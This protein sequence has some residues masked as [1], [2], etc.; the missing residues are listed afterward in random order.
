MTEKFNILWRR[1]LDIAWVVLLVLMPITSFPILSRLA[2]NTSVAPASFIPLVWLILFWFTYYLVKR[3]KVPRESIPFLFFIFVALVSCALG[4]FLDIPPFKGGNVINAEIR[5]LATLAVGAAFYFVTSSW[6]SQSCSRLEA[7]FKW[8]NFSGLLVFI[9]ATIQCVFIYLNHG[10]YPQYALNFQSLISSGSVF[11]SRIMGFAYEPSWLGHQLNLFFLPFW[12]A[13]TVCGWST[14]RFRIWKFSL[15]NIFLGYSVILLFLA[16]RIGTLSLLL[17]VAFLVINLNVHLA[18]RIQSW[19]VDRFSRFSSSFQHAVRILLP[20]IIVVGSI[21]IYVLGALALVWVLSFVDPRLSVIFKIQ[22]MVQ[23]KTLASNIY[24]LFNYL[25]FAE[26][27][28]YWV[29]G[30]NIFNSHPFFG[31]GLGNAGFYFQ[32]VIPAYGWSLP[33]IM[34]V[35]LRSA[36]LPNIKSLW[37]RLL[38]ETGIVGFSSFIAWCHVMVRTA[39]AICVNHRVSFKLV[40]WFG[41]FVL[42]SFITEGFSTDTFALPYLWV[43]LGIVSAA[44]ALWRNSEKQQGDIN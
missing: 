3:G 9:W 21:G 39:R 4:L 1:S 15:E 12:L 43:S 18:R 11:A 23:F 2:G 38:A 14:Y 28:V 22:S 20:G 25:Q 41:L 34:Q 10:V 5:A 7:S 13:A 30:W 16:S 26:R 36:T 6:L 24:E 40:G 33:E 42:I 29:A 17:V 37:V 35:Y 32:N 31:V 27:Y 44:G 8:I 19:S